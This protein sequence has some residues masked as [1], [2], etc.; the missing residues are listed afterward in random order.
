MCKYYVAEGG[1]HF[2][3]VASLL[4]LTFSARDAFF[5]TNRRAIATIFV[6][7]SVNLSDRV[8]AQFTNCIT[9]LAACDHSCVALAS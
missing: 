3:G 9:D 4:W 1:I 8:S 7:L 2:D 6:S 5:T